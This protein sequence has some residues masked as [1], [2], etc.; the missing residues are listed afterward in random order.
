MMPPSH[1][2][3]PVRLLCVAG[4]RPNFMK[5]APLLAELRRH[6]RFAPLLVH[7]GQHYDE[8]MSGAFFRDL[9][10]PA[11]DFFLG[12]APGSHAQQTAVIM[13]RFEPVLVETNPDAV[14]V[15]GDVNSTLACA[16]VAAKLETPVFHIESGLRS[17]DRSMPEEINRLLTDAISTLLFV[18]EESGVRNLMAEGVPASRIHL[19]GNLMIDSLLGH[20]EQAKARNVPLRLGVVPGGYGVVTLHRPANV[21]QMEA[22]REILG[23]LDEISRQLPL[24]FPVHPRTRARMAESGLGSDGS[25]RFLDPLGYLDFLSLMA[26]AA[27]VFTDSGGIQ[28]ETTALGI[29]CFT[30]RENT[31]RPAT[32]EHGTNR[33]AGVRRDSILAAWSDSQRLP[34]Q[35]RVP[36]LWDGKAASRCR[37]VLERYYFGA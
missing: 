28:E 16:L 22:L 37:E 9:S 35:P 5:L 4:A 13:Q 32:I 23:A 21:D 3:R 18:T 19:V 30:L 17:F 2:A 33:L 10:L 36:P 27:A 12:P 25:L 7:T 31:E 1:D 15:A 34:R 11:P 24:L 29:P 26:H 8:S 20:V 14:I 6:P